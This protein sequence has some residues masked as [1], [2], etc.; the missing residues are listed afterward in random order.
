MR[1]TSLCKVSIY[2]ITFFLIGISCSPIQQ[3]EKQ[4]ENNIIIVDDEGD[5]DFTSVLDAVMHAA[6]GD[7]IKVYSGT[8][9]GRITITHQI[10]LKGINQEFES[11]FDSGKPVLTSSEDIGT[12]ILV[13]ADGCEISGFLINPGIPEGDEYG[14]NGVALHSK[15][16]IVSNNVLHIGN[17]GILAYIGKDTADCSNNFINNN[18]LSGFSVA[19]QIEG[20]ECQVINNEIFENNFGIHIFDA[21][22]VSVLKN[23]FKNNYLDAFVFWIPFSYNIY[24]PRPENVRFDGNFYD[25][26][27]YSF[28]KPILR[29]FA[30]LLIPI[31]FSLTYDLHPVK[32]P[33]DIII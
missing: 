15:D 20:H 6:N 22:D 31:I 26:W 10:F 7:I 12:L 29:G 17:R 27:I 13:E 1:N 8:Y 18:S 11:G 16:N 23:N 33:Y 19:I 3:S 2:L 21:N 5:G 25:N 30:P 14:N 4:Q 28:P 9:E 32:E 24:Y